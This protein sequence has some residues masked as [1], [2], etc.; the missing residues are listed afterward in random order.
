MLRL[1][2]TCSTI[3]NVSISASE[4]DED[5]IAESQVPT[6]SSETNDLLVHNI[7]MSDRS[8]GELPQSACPRIKKP[9]TP[10][11]RRAQ[12]QDDKMNQTL[13]NMVKV[14]SERNA[15]R[16][17]VMSSDDLFGQSI[18]KTLSRFTPHQNAVA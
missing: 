8:D 11:K 7:Q 16:N 15:P 13:E 10:R 6:P 3:S 14:F 1:F 9:A 5:N 4:S 17:I 18:G 2:L 12:S